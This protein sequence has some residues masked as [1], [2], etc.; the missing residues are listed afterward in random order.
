MMSLV[1]RL[2]VL[3][4]LLLAL[5]APAQARV[6]NGD[7]AGPDEYPWSVALVSAGMPPVLGQFCGGSLVAPDAVLTAAHC[8]MGTP[9]A[10]IEVFA[11]DHDLGDAVPSE[12]HAV[13]SIRLP[14]DAEVD[15]DTTGAPRRDMAIL[16]LAQP[17]AGAEPIAPVPPAGEVDWAPG[18]DLEVMGWGLWEQASPPFP[19]LL[20]HTTVDR[21]SDAACGAVW[22]LDFFASDMVCAL[23]T[24]GDTVF[25]SCNGDSG[26]PLT[27]HPAGAD[28]TDASD[29]RLVGVVS[30]GS[31]LCNDPGAPGV[32]ARVGAPDLNA[33]VEAF[34]DGF[35]AGDPAAQIEPAGGLPALGGTP[36]VGQQLTCD[37]GTA[38]WTTTPDTVE[39]RIRLRD[40]EAEDYVTVAVGPAYTLTSSDAGLQFVCELHAKKSGVGGYGVARSTLSAPVAPAST[41]TTTPTDTTKTTVTPPPVTPP[42]VTP[43]PAPPDPQPFVPEPRDQVSPRTS[44]ISKRCVRRRC[45]LTIRATDAGAVVSGVSAVDLTLTT[46]YRCTRRGRARTCI[47]RTELTAQQVLP[48]VFRTRTAKLPRR[49]QNTLSVR[50]LDGAGNEELRPRL[51]GFLL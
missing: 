10:E 16:Q 7:D 36:K 20:Q 1:R 19:D 25:D 33:F 6:M 13:T 35:Q 21:V 32:Y 2:L 3:I 34:R 9:A 14:H 41:T 31:E 15:P 48:G 12:I 23:R 40:P 22:T 8:T 46:R 38:T 51:Y 45:V 37:P 26:G 29:F 27:T 18:A 28:P 39:R 43:K 4:A 30:F 44:R 24:S 5:P 11:G 50:A 17:V 42:P 47:R 49:S